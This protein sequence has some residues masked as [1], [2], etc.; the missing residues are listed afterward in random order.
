MHVFSGK[1][2]FPPKLTQLLQS[3]AYATKRVSKA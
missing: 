2:L 1:N 3:Y